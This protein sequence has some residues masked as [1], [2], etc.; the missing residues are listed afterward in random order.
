MSGNGPLAPEDSAHKYQTSGSPDDSEDDTENTGDEE[1]VHAAVVES[2]RVTVTFRRPDD[3]D[4]QYCVHVDHS[5]HDWSPLAS[6]ARRSHRLAESTQWDP[7]G[8]VDWVDLPVRVRQAVADAVAGVEERGELDP[9]FR[10]IDTESTEATD[11]K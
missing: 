5:E 3:R 4:L 2:Q 10:V 8:E 6:F 7:M 11:D 1:P 9:G